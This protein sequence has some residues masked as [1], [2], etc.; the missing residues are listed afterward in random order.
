MNDNQILVG[1]SIGNEKMSAFPHYKLL[2]KV[3]KSEFD[4]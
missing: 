1:I 4:Q 3:W 2:K